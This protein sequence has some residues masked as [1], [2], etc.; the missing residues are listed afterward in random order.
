MQAIRI[1][2]KHTLAFELHW[3]QHDE[4]GRS[5]HAQIAKWRSDGYTLAGSYS[6]PNG[7][8]YGLLKTPETPLAKGT[9]SGAAVIATNPEL[10]GKTG[11]VLIEVTTGSETHVICVGLRAGVVIL[12]RLVPVEGVGDV[13]NY[14]L[15]QHLHGDT[16]QTWGDVHSVAAVDHAFSADNLTPARKGGK[17]VAIADLRSA[18]W[19]AVIG[20]LAGVAVLGGMAY[21]WLQMDNEHAARMAALRLQ[22]QQTPG[23]LYSQSLEAW[24][25]RP[26]YPAA[27]AIEAVRV[28]FASFPTLH[29]GWLLN[30]VQ[31]APKACAVSWSRQGGTLS[32][33]RAAAPTEW[34][35]INPVDQDQIGMTVAIDLPLGKHNQAA[36]PKVD[37]Y[38]DG[39]VALWQFLSPGGW[40]ASLGSVQQVGIPDTFNAEQRRGVSNFAGAPLAYMV[41]VKDQALWYAAPDSKSP[42]SVENLGQYVELTDPPSVEL[43][44]N[45]KEILFSFLGTAYVQK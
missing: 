22:A 3:E 14:F 8:V 42:V 34:Q 23:A 6:H 11:L 40:K 16:L 20:G 28:R 41:T 30:K 43:T 9:L 38:R 26:V 21:L 25:T 17:A 36:W 5:E 4:L 33:F 7:R 15:S 45:S 19:P 2:P 44:F 31:C 13:R 39:V 1:S 18:R 27:S 10:R 29:A 37:E 24:R 32:E 12:D 35:N